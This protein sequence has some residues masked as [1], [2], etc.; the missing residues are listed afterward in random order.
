[1]EQGRQAWVRE[2]DAVEVDVGPGP[3]I[4]LYPIPYSAEGKGG[5]RD[6]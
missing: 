1:M 2:Q 3:L 4:A 5:W 6:W